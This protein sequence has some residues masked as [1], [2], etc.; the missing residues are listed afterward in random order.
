MAKEI[1]STKRLFVDAKQLESEGVSFSNFHTGLEIECFNKVFN[2][3]SILAKSYREKAISLCEEYLQSG[4]DT[5]ITESPSF[6]S[7]WRENKKHIKEDSAL[8]NETTRKQA[9]LLTVDNLSQDKS[10]VIPLTLKEV[11]NSLDELPLETN[12]KENIFEQKT[13]WHA[14]IA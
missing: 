13:W 5:F 12:D 2:K 4:Y 7:I 8:Q 6:F 11:E 3:V 10:K 14:Y 9:Q 1:M